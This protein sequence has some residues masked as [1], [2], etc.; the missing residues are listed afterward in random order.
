MPTSPKSAAKALIAK[1]RKVLQ[2]NWP[3]SCMNFRC[4]CDE[5][6]ASYNDPCDSCGHSRATHRADHEA[7]KEHWKKITEFA[8]SDDNLEATIDLLEYFVNQAKKSS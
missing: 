4:A 6:Q 7:E 8:A 1:W 5:Q 3:V 2:H